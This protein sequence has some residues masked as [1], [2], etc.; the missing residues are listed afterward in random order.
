MS[1]RVCEERTNL[2]KAAMLVAR[3][4]SAY[5][6]GEMLKAGQLVWEAA[7]LLETAQENNLT[8]LESEVSTPEPVSH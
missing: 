2:R 8:H 6:N 5:N 3:A 1:V 4:I 7:H